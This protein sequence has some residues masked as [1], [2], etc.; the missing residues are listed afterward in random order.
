MNSFFLVFESL[1]EYS[2][3]SGRKGI[4]NPPDFTSTELHD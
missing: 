1:V 2:P 3:F 4:L